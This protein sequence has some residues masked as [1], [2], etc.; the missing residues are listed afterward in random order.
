M[1]E[2]DRLIQL[3]EFVA[4]FGV[5]EMTDDDFAEYLDLLAGAREP[6]APGVMVVTPARYLLLR[7]AQDECQ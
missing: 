6:L 5:S 7:G 2:P 4:H 1:S 3:R